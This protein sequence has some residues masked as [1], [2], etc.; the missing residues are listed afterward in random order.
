MVMAHAPVILPA[1]LGR[2]LPYRPVLWVPLVLLH[3][4]LLVR[5]VG[6][7]SGLTAVWQAGGVATVVAMIAFLLTAVTL[8]VRG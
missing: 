7:L 6:A 1:V 4:G 3:A 2:P 5:F 8:V